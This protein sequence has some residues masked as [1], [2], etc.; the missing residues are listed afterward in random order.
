MSRLSRT[1]NRT[2]LAI[3]LLLLVATSFACDDD[4]KTAPDKCG[5]PALQIYDIQSAGEPADDNAKYPCLT[6]IGHSVSSI[7]PAGGSTSSTTTGGNGGGGTGGKASTGGTGGKAS[8]G[9][10]GGK[11]NNGGAGK[12]STAGIGGLGL[13]GLGG[14]GGI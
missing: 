7:V 2:T 3:G 5:D 13:A 10:T 14:V 4:G 11:S 9:G 12:S 6:K 1:P 8:T